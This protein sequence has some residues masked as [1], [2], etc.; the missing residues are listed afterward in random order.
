MGWLAGLV[1]A[2]VALWLDAI[3][4]DSK[5]LSRPSRAEWRPATRVTNR[6]EDRRQIVS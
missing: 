4:L 5:V 1:A 3:T 2:R 6:S